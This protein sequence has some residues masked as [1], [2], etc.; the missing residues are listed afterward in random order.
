[1]EIVFLKSVNIN[2]TCIT[3]FIGNSCMWA[4]SIMNAYIND[5]IANLKQSVEIGKD[6]VEP[7]YI[8]GT[9]SRGLTYTVELVSN[10]GSSM[11]FDVT[12][13]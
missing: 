1:M 9:F 13:T 8:I 10:F 3:S 5:Q 12:F 2:S 11:T 7:V 6:S 4:I